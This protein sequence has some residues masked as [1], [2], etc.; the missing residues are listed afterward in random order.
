MTCVCPECLRLPDPGPCFTHLK[1][2]KM[3][4]RAVLGPEAAAT[5]GRAELR[6]QCRLHF[7]SRRAGPLALLVALGPG[8][9]LKVGLSGARGRH[10]QSSG[11]SNSA[12]GSHRTLDTP[13]IHI[14]IHFLVYSPNKHT[15]NWAVPHD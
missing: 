6:V 7:T 10:L 5:C 3:P 1:R 4:C 9:E 14:F 8:S 12:T 15:A 13:F 2:C 11:N